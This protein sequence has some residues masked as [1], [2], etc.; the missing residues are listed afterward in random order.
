MLTN[1]AIAFLARTSASIYNEVAKIMI[2]PHIRTA[3]WCVVVD[4][5]ISIRFH[6]CLCINNRVSNFCP[7]CLAAG[8][9]LNLVPLVPLQMLHKIGAPHIRIPL[10]YVNQELL[11]VVLVVAT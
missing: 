9:L 10:H 11:I 5:R 3:L 4:E 2:L 6:R 1:W 7:R 8:L